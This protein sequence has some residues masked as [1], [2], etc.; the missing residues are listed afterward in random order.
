LKATKPLDLSFKKQ[1]A[2]TKIVFS[3][4]GLEST[5][6]SHPTIKDVAKQAG[7]SI[8]TV[9]FVMNNRTDV[10]ISDEVKRRVLKVA[11]DLDYHPS[12]MAAGLAGRRTRNLGV[13]FY[14]QDQII[15]N[16]FYS[17]V[18]E[19]IVKETIEKNFNLYFS[20]LKS[21]YTGYQSLPK[22][23][24]EKN[25]DGVLLMGHCDLQTVSDIKERR[26][27][28]VAIDNYP[29]LK[30]VDT[31][32]IDNKQGGRIAA[33]HLT[34]LG[35]KNLSLLTISKGR[36]SIE[37]RGEGWKEAIAKSHLSPSQSHIYECQDLSFQGGYEKTREILKKDKKITAL[38][39]VN[40]EMAAGAIRAAREIG[41]KV[42]SDL[43][44]VGFDNIAISQYTDPPL[45]TIQV[46]KEH[47]GK[48]AVTR[49]L[50]II[51]N[52]D[53]AVLRQEVPVE[54]LIRN[55]TAKPQ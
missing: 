10:M 27:P 19:G 32:Q 1:K 43:S 47:M 14:Q 53:T 23:I 48:L 29:V 35:H 37:E 8:T 24:R 9:S 28:V 13:V 38:F 31:V 25:V 41:R 55:S 16:Q 21:E 20:Y 4:A 18:I 39:C 49:I 45:T 11:Q 50:E 33:E 12:A 44:V 46:P 54:L 3:K 22:I 7:V 2:K 40:D 52:K 36:P 34:G 42:P 17:Y 30:E 5:M 15:S 26:I 51:E 6:G